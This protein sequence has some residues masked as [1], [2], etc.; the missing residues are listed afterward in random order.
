[1]LPATQL[2]SLS[3]SLSLQWQVD[4]Q[5]SCL[6]QTQVLAFFCNDSRVDKGC[7]MQSYRPEQGSYEPL[8]AQIFALT[9]ASQQNLLPQC[10]NPMRVLHQEQLATAGSLTQVSKMAALLSRP[11]IWVLR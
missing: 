10:A 8:H 3:L 9:Y 7:A 4:S 1:M 5:R 2:W 6:T 11:I